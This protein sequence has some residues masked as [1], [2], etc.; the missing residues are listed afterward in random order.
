MNGIDDRDLRRNIFFSNIIGWL[1]IISVAIPFTIISQ[2]Y[3]PPLIILPG[4]GVFVIL[5]GLLLN[6]LGLNIVGRL[7]IGLLP[8]SLCSLYI[9]SLTPPGEALVP[10]VVYVQLSFALTP[11]LIF[12]LRERIYIFFSG[13]YTFFFIV[14]VTPMVKEMVNIPLNLDVIKFGWLS[15]FTTSVGV[16]LAFASLM[17][18]ARVTKVAIDRSSRLVEETDKNNAQLQE[19]E[20]ALKERMQEIELAQKNEQRRNWSTNGLSQ[21]GSVLQSR[22]NLS[23]VC[24]QIL[25]FL[26]DYL[27]VTQGGLY[28]VQDEEGEDPGIELVATYAYDRKKFLNK[29]FELQEGLLGSAYMEKDVIHLREIPEEYIHIRSGLGDAPPKTLLIMPMVVNEKVEGLIE[30]ATF[31]SFE[32]FEIDFLREAGVTVA[33]AVSNIKVNEQ[34]RKLLEVSQTQAQE[35][36]AQEEEMRQNQEELQATQ[37]ELARQR[38]ELQAEIA[39]LRSRLEGVEV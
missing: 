20:L 2:I 4:G 29:R 15:Y 5:G 16:L 7:I 26:V 19:S 10:A 17:V 1:V 31:K 18:L 22:A 36:R 32:D 25:K 35:M 13:A 23:E 27:E 14:V 28:I 12:D 33:A 39:E 11:L 38:S 9:S 34:T 24:D 6:R 30:L 8:L 37:E 21:I 3:F